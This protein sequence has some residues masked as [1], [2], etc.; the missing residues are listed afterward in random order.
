MCQ[1]AGPQ[2][3]Q[4][5]GPSWPGKPLAAPVGEEQRPQGTDTP[6]SLPSLLPHS[7]ISLPP[8]CLLPINVK[9]GLTAG[10]CAQFPQT[11]FCWAACT[12][13]AWILVQFFCLLCPHTLFLHACWCR[14]RERGQ[15]YPKNTLSLE[16]WSPCWSLCCLR[17]RSKMLMNSI[18]G[19]CGRGLASGGPH[20]RARVKS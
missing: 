16:S 6:G 7:P 14:A 1:Q 11:L 5:L 15:T 10:L 13:V 12:L 17:A 4:V 20:R 8:T 2:A 18:F 3:P 19:S 9:V